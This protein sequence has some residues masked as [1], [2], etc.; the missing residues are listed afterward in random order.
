MTLE[1][2][3][4][5]VLNES[6]TIQEIATEM[7]AQ[8]QLPILQVKVFVIDMNDEQSLPLLQSLMGKA[9]EC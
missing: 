8:G 4:A 5:R 2:E 1:S 6:A 9:N 3:A 7:F